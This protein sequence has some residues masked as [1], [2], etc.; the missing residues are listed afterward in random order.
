MTDD[1]VEGWTGP[2]DFALLTDGA[3]LNGTG[4]TVTLALRDR[5]EGVVNVTGNVAWLV[6]AS[7]TV[8]FSPSAED[9][10]AARSPYQ[11]RF[12]VTDGSSKDVFFPNAEPM[13]WVVR[14]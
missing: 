8:R 14:K 2:L 10:K 7:G 3:A 1:L 11:A 12:K 13:K 6:Q 4:L 5:S 9:L